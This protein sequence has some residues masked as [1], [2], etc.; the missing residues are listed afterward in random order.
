MPANFT[1]TNGFTG[2]GGAQ[3]LGT[4]ASSEY[5]VA[6]HDGRLMCGIIEVEVGTGE[7]KCLR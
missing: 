6:T 2:G 3:S 7:L 4:E 1:A 5:I